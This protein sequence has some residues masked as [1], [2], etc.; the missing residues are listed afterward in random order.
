MSPVPASRA[1]ILV[2]DDN[3]NNLRIMLEML[4]SA[5]YEVLIANSGSRAL[6]QIPNRSPDLILLDVLM[7]AM[8]GFETCRRLKQDSATSMI[9]VIFMTALADVEYKVRGF[10]AGGV[11][12]I[13][14]PFQ[15]AEVLARLSTHLE[16]RTLQ[17]RLE[18]EIAEVSTVARL[19]ALTQIPNRV[20]WEEAKSRYGKHILRRGPVGVIVIDVNNL[21]RTNDTLGH[22]AGDQLLV[23]VTNVVLS[24]IR[25]NDV[26]ARVGGD[27]FAL[28]LPD[29][30]TTAC[31]AVSTRLHDE[32][33]GASG[34]L[35]IPVSFASGWAVCEQGQNLEVTVTEADARMYRNK[36]AARR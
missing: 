4:T 29:L 20:H 19:D 18:V 28:L 36:Q 6:Y 22:Q 23:A 10:T 27:E 12:Y 13:T 21:K 7:P 30:G 17:Q 16:I 34:P 11:D 9:P 15:H 31:E 26:F 35:G 14:K 25:P 1:T 33:A 5:G 24:V 8:D 2:V 3:P 32:A